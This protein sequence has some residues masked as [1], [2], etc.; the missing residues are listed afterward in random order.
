MLKRY[1]RKLI[2]TIFSLLFI[3]LF[4]ASAGAQIGLTNAVP[5]YTQNFDSLASTGSTATWTDNVTL[6]GWYATE[7]GGSGSFPGTY[8]VG[9][10]SS[11]TGALYSFGVAGTHAIT[12][13]CLGS[14]SSGTPGTLYYGI[15]FKNNGTSTITS[16]MVS[17]TG[18]QWRN[19]GV[20]ATQTNS[21]AYAINPTNIKTGTYTNVPALN[22]ANL[23]GTTTAAALDGNAPANRAALSATISGLSVAPGSE[24]WL[25]ISD[26]NDAGNDHGMGIDDM[27]VTATFSAGSVTP[28]SYYSLA[29]G[30]LDTVSTWGTN[31]DGTGTHPT[32]F[33]T[34]SQYFHIANGNPGT[35]SGSSWTV[36][37]GSFIDLDNTTNLTIP[38]T[39]VVNGMVNVGAG[40]TLNIKNATLPTLDTINAASTI[41]FTGLTSVVIPALTYGNITFDN[42]TVTIPGTNTAL[43]FAGNFTLQNG[44]SFIGANPTGYSLTTTGNGNQTINANGL[45]LTMRNFDIGNTN[46]KTSGTVTLAPSTNITVLNS[47]MMNL[48]APAIFADGGNTITLSNNASVT[49]AASGYNL[50]GTLLVANVTSGTINIRGAAA[51]TTP[52]PQFYNVTINTSGTSSLAFNTPGTA[53]TITIK[54]N[55]TVTSI[56]SGG[57][58]L[59]NLNTIQI[60]GN[61]VY[62]PATNLFKIA[63]STIQFNGTA[64]QQYSSNVAAGDTFNNVVMTNG[65]GLILNAPMNI[66]GTLTLT[67]GNITTG[68]N[69]LNIIGTGSVSGAN[70]TSYVNGNLSKVISGVTTKNYEVGDITYSPVQLNFD[71]SASGGSI[72]VKSTTGSHP[73]IATAYINTADFVNRYWTVTNAGVTGFTTMNAVFSYNGGDITGGTGNTGYMV[74]QY[75]GTSWSTAP[76]FSTSTTTAAPLLSLSSTASNEPLATFSADYVTGAPTCSGATAGTATA[77]PSSLCG[78]GTSVVSLSGGS[79]GVGVTYQW[80]SSTDSSTWAPI[81]GATA[82]SYSPSS[83]SVTTFY[84]CVVSCIPTATNDSATTKVTVNFAPTATISGSAAITTGASTNLTFGG[85]AFDTITYNA[86]GGADQT[87]VLDGTGSAI[88]GVS[89]TGNTTYT[90]TSVTSAAGCMSAITGQSA[91]VSVSSTPTAFVTGTTTICAG[92]STDITFTGTAN[93]IL[94]YNVNGGTALFDTLDASGNSVISVSPTT[95]SSYNLTA[96]QSGAFSGSLSNT[97]TVTVNSLP[98]ASVSGTTTICNG[99]SANITFSGDNNDTVTY[100]LNSGAPQS[101]ILDGTG[102]AIISVTPATTAMYN[103]TNVTSPAG[104]SAAITGTATVTVLSLPI[105]S[106]SGTTSI[107]IGSGTNIVFNGDANDTVTYNVDGG[108]PAT[109]VLDGTGSASLPVSPSA[110]TNYNITS[111]KSVAG[112]TSAVTGTATITVITTPVASISGTTSSCSGS[113]TNILFSG[114]A[115]DTVTYTINGGAPQ[116]ITLDGTGNAILTVAPITNTTYAITNVKSPAGCSA[117]VSGSAVVTILSLPVASI[118]GTTTIITGTSTN[119]TFTGDANDTVTYTVNGTLHTISINGAGD[120]VLNVTPTVTTTYALVSVKSPNG[121]TATATGNAIVT[122]N[123]VPFSTGNIV[124]L[125]ENG[126]TSAGNSLSLVEYSPSGAI[127]NTHTLPA[128]GIGSRIV[129]SGSATSEG[130]I[131]LD[132]E[133]THIIVPGYDTSVGFASVASATNINRIIYSVGQS[134]IGTEVVNVPQSAAF[135][136]NNMRTATANGTTYYGGGASTTATL[137]GVMLMG[138]GTATQISTGVK[139]IRVVNIYNG[140][141]YYSSSSSPTVGIYSLGTGAPTTSAVSNPFIAITGSPSPYGFSISPDGQT[142]YVADDASST[143]GVQKWTL[144]SGAWTKQYTLASTLGARSLTVDYS[145]YPNNTIYA[146]TSIG[147][148]DTL[149]KIIDSS[150][151]APVTRLAAA[152]A[153]TNFRGITFAPSCFAKVYTLSPS[154]CNGNTAKVVFYGNP[155]AIVTYNLNGGSNQTVTL[156]NTGTDTVTTA[157][158]TAT[159]T[160]NLVSVTTS[161]CTN[162]P[163]TGSAVITVSIPP[164]ASISGDTAACTSS[165]ANVIFTGDANDTVRYNVNGVGTLSITLNGAG[166]ATLTPTLGAGLTTYN[167]VSVTS[168]ATCVSALTGHLTINT[169]MQGTWM[170]GTS[171]DW[172]NA[173]NWACNTVPTSAT[174]AIIPAGT[175]FSPSVLSGAVNTNDLSIASGVVVTIA[176][177]AQLNV[178]GNLANAGSVVSDGQLVITGAGTHNLT[179]TGTINNLTINAATG[180]TIPAG[181]LVNI[182]GT[183]IVS[184]GTLTTNG[185]LTLVSNASGTGRIGNSAGTVSGNIN[186]QQY[187]PGGRRAYRFFGHPFNVSIPLSQLETYIDITGMGGISHGF[188]STPSNA[189]SCMWYSTRR[190][191]SALSADPG[192]TAFTNTNGLDTNAFKPYE[193]IYLFIRGAKGTG[194]DGLPYTPAPVTVSMTGSINQGTVAMPLVKG[195]NSD[196][197]QISNPYPSPVDLGSVVAAAHSTGNVVGAGFYMWDP[198]RATGGA[199]IAIPIGSAYKIQGNTSFQVEAGTSSSVLTFHETDKVATADTELLRVA[200]QYVDI[201][202]VDANYTVWD[203]LK[204]KFDAQEVDAKNNDDA[205]KAV[206]PDLNFYT[207]SP[208]GDHMSIDARPYTDGKVIPLGLTTNHQQSFVIRA[209]DMAAPVGAQLYLHDKYL[210]TYTPLTQGTEYPFTISSDVKS[211]GDAR[212]EIGL[213]AIPDGNNTIAGTSFSMNV[214]PNPATSQVVL[215]YQT[216]GKDDSH[217]RVL[218][219]A[220]VEVTTL[221]LGTQ[222]SGNVTIPVNKLPAGIYIVELTSG[223]KKATQ[224]LIKE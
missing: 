27:T 150:A 66:S 85:E 134:A 131:T 153:G 81:S 137:G 115:N 184:T 205:G 138:S 214:T 157:A 67:T 8:A 141:L 30:N 173:A 65:A 133:R 6:A 1:P 88:L 48:T 222:S 92:I 204:I 7:S 38:A 83:I 167:L 87:I 171:S 64:V 28:T 179:S 70:S 78:P 118:S 219:V 15:R 185:N 162:T 182:T 84:R 192:W 60:G 49:G 33:T 31:T 158:I 40:R 44:A 161:T 177:G 72:T 174:N 175:T 145:T 135:D 113:N 3:Q 96:I 53:S 99:S 213:G 129:G 208:A 107:C 140:Q 165:P 166:T 220:G 80:Q 223:D 56:G 183:L 151:T 152:P 102:T 121:C 52:A 100:N 170:G 155:G 149:I 57:I 144:V 32:D 139:N 62:T 45:I 130:Q 19:G 120:T 94:T 201:E 198:Y 105:A 136:G 13:R 93:A 212:F 202:V 221:D 146:T 20:V 42:S 124:V 22:F 210:A 197:N 79:S 178:N 51:N 86:N 224:R 206:N 76:A 111:V 156:L 203:D 132:A 217:V 176:S 186:V 108:S 215:S 55:L 95:T 200:N 23:I 127:L 10:G 29:T 63:N 4:A 123:P 211:Q 218:N 128:T 103:V 17:Y 35:F 58:T 143:K 116:F 181:N 74:R 168:P 169:Y 160:Y 61:I 46:A 89:P 43:T 114:D 50:T 106:I 110:T 142:C 98:V 194:L 180:A 26:P 90:I 164:T 163:V 112:C 195:A 97:A 125:Q 191:K 68:A 109:I 37:A 21:F 73:Q 9:T 16:L 91:I 11:T 193:G 2:T 59:G 154:V 122:V 207:L 104:C 77:S 148:P 75:N 34:A 199:F 119:I 190:G 126:I 5:A 159:T 12:D 47:L 188:T 41:Q 187:F 25:Q 216:S 147:T 69:S 14:L 36:G 101:I 196:F 82:S 39:T 18:E 54:N 172:N 189:T 117:T 209:T 24:I 71:A